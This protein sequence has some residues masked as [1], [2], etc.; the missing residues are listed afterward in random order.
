MYLT[1]P[2]YESNE[3]S[4]TNKIRL[5]KRLI[6][7]TSLTIRIGLKPISKSEYPNTYSWG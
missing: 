5:V 7:K 2:I 3:R 4:D 6:F 1:T